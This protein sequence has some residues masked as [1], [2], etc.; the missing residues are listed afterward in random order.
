MD[1]KANRNKQLA[2]AVTLAV[3]GTA[4]AAGSTPVYAAYGSSTNPVQQEEYLH[5]LRPG[6][7]LAKEEQDQKGTDVYVAAYHEN[8]NNTAYA[9][10]G[11]MSGKTL[12]IN[13]ITVTGIT[14]ASGNGA[15]HG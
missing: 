11:D 10:L 12:T 1:F 14:G 5:D 7:E 4:W 15:N 8:F 6:E 9:A 13:N 2:A 3:M